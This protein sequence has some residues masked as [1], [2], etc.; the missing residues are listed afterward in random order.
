MDTT[1]GESA[2]GKEGMVLGSDHPSP[3][4]LNVPVNTVASMLPVFDGPPSQRNTGDKLPEKPLAKRMQHPQSTDS[5]PVLDTTKDGLHP[6]SVLRIVEHV[7]RLG[8]GEVGHDV[9]GGTVQH[10]EHVGALWVASVL[11]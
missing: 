10:L 2:P 8:K 3:R 9:K 5:S 6:G 7:Q 11:T 1:C 4:K